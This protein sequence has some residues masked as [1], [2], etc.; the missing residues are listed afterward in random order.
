MT[1]VVVTYTSNADIQARFPGK[2]AYFDDRYNNLAST[3]CDHYRTIPTQINR[4]SENSSQDIYTLVVHSDYEDTLKTGT[5]SFTNT[6]FIYRIPKNSS[7]LSPNM[8]G[9]AC[10]FFVD[11]DDNKIDDVIIQ[12][13]NGAAILLMFYNCDCICNDTRP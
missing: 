11:L 6:P 4:S 1:T 13:Y 8:F 12:G 5:F 2:K 7:I 9:S 10:A 3:G